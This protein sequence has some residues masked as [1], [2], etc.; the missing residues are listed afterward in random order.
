M[1][2]WAA[3]AERVNLTTRPWGQPQFLRFYSKSSFAFTLSEREVSNSLREIQTGILFLSFF[4]IA[5]LFNTLTHTPRPHVCTVCVY[6]YLHVCH[7]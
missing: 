5:C 6:L 4:L 7:H 2:A 3:E 1:K